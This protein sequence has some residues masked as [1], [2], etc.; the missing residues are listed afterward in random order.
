MTYLKPFVFLF[1]TMICLVSFTVVTTPSIAQESGV[2]AIGPR[3]GISGQAFLGKEQKYNFRL[4]DLAALVRLPWSL[5][6]GET[7]WRLETRL[8]TSIGAISGAGETGLLITLIPTLALTS[9]HGTWTI[10]GGAGPGIFSD[11]KFGDQNFGGPV[12]IVATI[13]ASAKVFSHGFAGLRL[14]HF[15]DATLY[16]KSSLGVDMYLMEVGYRF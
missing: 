11:Y 9:R 15:S 14:Q 13:G 8:I 2:I 5:A 6:L 3:V 1:M 12:Q 4:Y 7:G 16:G 10:D